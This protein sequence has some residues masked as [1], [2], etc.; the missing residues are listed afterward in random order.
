VASLHL[1]RL[2]TAAKP[3]KFAF[4]PSA[5]KDFGVR[6]ISEYGP[7]ETQEAVMVKKTWETP[8]LRVLG[9]NDAESGIHLGGVDLGKFS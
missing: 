1:C 4:I 6:K 8:V 2:A 5:G 3:V 7:H 9:A